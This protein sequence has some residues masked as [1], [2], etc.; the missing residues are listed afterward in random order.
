MLQKLGRGDTPLRVLAC[1]LHKEWGQVTEP[2][3]PLPLN[4]WTPARMPGNFEAG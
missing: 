2:L 1:E 3:I 4:I